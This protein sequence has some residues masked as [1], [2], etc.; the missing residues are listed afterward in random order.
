MVPLLDN[1]ISNLGSAI[2]SFYPIFF[3]STSMAKLGN[4]HAMLVVFSHRAWDPCPAH[5]E[6]AQ[7]YHV[8]V[9]PSL[10]EFWASKEASNHGK[11]SS[12]EKLTSK[13][14]NQRFFV[15]KSNYKTWKH[16]IFPTKIID[17]SDLR[18][19]SK[20]IDK[21][22]LMKQTCFWFIACDG[23]LPGSLHLRALALALVNLLSNEVWNPNVW[24]ARFLSSDTGW[25]QAC[26]QSVN[27]DDFRHKDA[28]GIA[29]NNAIVC[30]MN[31]ENTIKSPTILAIL[32]ARPQA[33]WCEI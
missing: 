6:E 20:W 14:K 24:R 23:W 21:L 26:P 3:N 31:F 12:P 10:F 32:R 15:N 22:M 7:L 1:G 27:W 33:L 25:F 17:L 19:H 13:E 2:R 29:F 9:S 28:G 4:D 8:G 5:A 18:L 16:R 11:K 30:L